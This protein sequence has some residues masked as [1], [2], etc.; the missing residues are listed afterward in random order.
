MDG[1]KPMNWT[2]SKFDIEWTRN[3]IQSLTEGGVWGLPIANG[4]TLRVFHSNKTYELT[5]Q[6]C[7]ERGEETLMRTLFVMTKIGY[8]PSIITDLRDTK[9]DAFSQFQQDNQ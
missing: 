8:V 1:W 2:P 5:V 7:D 6:P 3:H 9:D 4:S